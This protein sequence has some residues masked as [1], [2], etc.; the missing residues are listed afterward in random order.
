MV[1]GLDVN[2]VSFL[3]SSAYFECGPDYDVKKNVLSL[4]K[5]FVVGGDSIAGEV[6]HLLYYFFASLCFHFDYL[7]RV[8]PKQNKLQASLFFTN[9]PNHAKDAATVRF[10]WN[11]TALMPSFTGLPPHVNILAQLEGLKVVLESS[12]NEIINGVK[13][14]H[15]GRRRLGSQSYFDKEEMIAK[16]GELHSDLMKK[17]KVVGHKASTALQAGHEGD[18]EFGSGGDRGSTKKCHFFK[19]P[20]D[21]FCVE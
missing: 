7:V 2:D 12:K 16:M 14:D 10:P 20:L 9:I 4:L 19:P 17:I 21:H 1:S 18:F 11:K 15:D 8:L 5:E 13:N 6:C 3:I